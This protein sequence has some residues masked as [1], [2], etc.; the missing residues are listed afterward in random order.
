VPW[1]AGLI[2]ISALGAYGGGAH[3]ISFGMSWVLNFVLSLVVYAMA[4][5]VRLHPER[6]Q[7]TMNQ[8]AQQPPQA[9]QAS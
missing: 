3:V 4:I 9:Q 1:L 5:A 8:S 2:A 6:V 7:Q